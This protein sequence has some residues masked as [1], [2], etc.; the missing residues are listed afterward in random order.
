MNGS[1]NFPER[2]TVQLGHSRHYQS[3]L[4]E[5]HNCAPEAR[6][7]PFS[8][9]HILFAIIGA[10]V[11]GGTMGKS[12]PFLGLVKHLATESRNKQYRQHR[13]PENA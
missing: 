3:T 2:Y 7:K 13:H 11:S 1:V 4:I 12:Q 8:G 5:W 9:Q 6:P 10:F